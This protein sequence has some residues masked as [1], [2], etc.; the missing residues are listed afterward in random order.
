MRD[1]YLYP[2]SMVLRNLLDI[3]DEDALNLAEAEL[4]R[5]SMMLMYEQ[6]FTDFS[7]QGFQKI[8]KT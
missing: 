7:S 3:H 1:P 5:A 2:G 8:H 4:S 6:G